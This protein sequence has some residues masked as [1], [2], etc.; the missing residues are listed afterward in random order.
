MKI[1]QNIAVSHT[2]V[3]VKEVLLHSSMI[4]TVFITINRIGQNIL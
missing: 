3:S 2:N 4:L 1:T